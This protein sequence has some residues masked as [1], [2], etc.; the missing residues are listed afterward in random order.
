[1][2]TVKGH[3]IPYGRHIPTA[4]AISLPN[5]YRKKNF[6]VLLYPPPPPPPPPPP[7]SEN[8]KPQAVEILPRVIDKD[9]LTH[10]GQMMHARVIKLII[11]GSD[12][13]HYLNQCWNIVNWALRNKLQW[14]YNRHLNI[15]IQENA[16]V[17]CKMVAILSRP[18]C[19]NSLSAP[20][21]H[22]VHHSFVIKYDLMLWKTAGLCF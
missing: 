19:V 13:G 5:N 15:L 16:F 9:L 7:H 2:A 21:D 10:W 12:N 3:F 20:G 4:C 17:L 6:Q 1:M 8:S 14:N 18:Q 11:I 22:Q